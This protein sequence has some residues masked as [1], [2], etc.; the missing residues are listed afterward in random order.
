MSTA[1]ASELVE[2]LNKEHVREVDALYTEQMEIREELVRIVQLMQ[3]E[4]LPRE[5]QM[6]D[7]IE[8]MHDAHEQATKHVHAQLG[9]FAKGGL[10]GAQQQQKADLHDPLKDMEEELSRIDKLLS[11]GEV[12]PDIAGWKPQQSKQARA[13]PSPA[14]T[15]GSPDR[16][17]SGTNQSANA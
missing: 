16:Q 1:L 3:E 17:R 13:P 11:H 14:S 2:D 10:S 12:R 5:K 6:H 4:I 9:D 15:R 7:M 8:K